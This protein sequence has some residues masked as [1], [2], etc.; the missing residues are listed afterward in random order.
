MNGKGPVNQ[1]ARQTLITL[2]EH[3]ENLLRHI[4]NCGSEIISTPAK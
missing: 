4:P 3:V 1:R 2:V